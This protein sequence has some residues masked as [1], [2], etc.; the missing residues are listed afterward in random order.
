MVLVFFRGLV[1]ICILITSSVESIISYG[2]SGSVQNRNGYMKSTRQQLLKELYDTLWYSPYNDYAYKK[3]LYVVFTCFVFKLLSPPTWRKEGP[4]YEL[5]YGLQQGAGLWW[6]HKKNLTFGT[7][8]FEHRTFEFIIYGLIRPKID[9]DD[10]WKSWIYPLL[11]LS[12]SF[13]FLGVKYKFLRLTFFNLMD[14]VR[15][16]DFCHEKRVGEKLASPWYTINDVF[17]QRSLAIF[18]YSLLPRVSIDMSWF[19]EN[20]KTEIHSDD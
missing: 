3:C 15:L 20:N 13:S 19:Y 8:I 10:V 6:E 18:I 4:G 7:F 14:V 12:L 17:R 5:Y 2:G 16:L 11:F 9:D 1:V